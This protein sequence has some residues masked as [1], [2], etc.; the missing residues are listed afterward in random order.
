[1]N[2]VTMWHL[3]LFFFQN[4]HHIFTTVRARFAR[5]SFNKVAN[6]CVDDFT[7]TPLTLLSET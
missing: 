2:N 7:E 3:I 4:C 5:I 1:M 6:V